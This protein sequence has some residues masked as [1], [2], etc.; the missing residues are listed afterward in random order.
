MKE[1]DMIHLLKSIQKTIKKT[2]ERSALDVH[3]ALVDIRASVEDALSDMV[4]NPTDVV[5]VVRGGDSLV[6]FADGTEYS[7]LEGYTPPQFEEGK[8]QHTSDLMFILDTTT[9]NWELVDWMAGISLMELDE[10]VGI[11]K[12]LREE[13]LKKGEKA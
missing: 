13:Q 5:E 11:C 6:R 4:K 9:Y 2:D 12:K 3:C 10:V 7:I 8:L 1:W